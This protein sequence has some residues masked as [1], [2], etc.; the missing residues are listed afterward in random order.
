MNTRLFWFLCALVQ[1]SLA[2]GCHKTAPVQN[3]PIPDT[4]SARTFLALGDSYTIGES[5][6]EVERFPAQTISLLRAKGIAVKSPVY[7]ARTGWT[8]ANL[9][10]AIEQAT[11][12]PSYDIVTLLIGVNDQY[13]GKDTAGYRTRFTQL[14]QRSIELS[15]RNSKHVY[16]LSIP[17]YGVTPFGGGSQRISREIDDFNKINKEVSLAYGAVYIDITPI[18]R[19][20]ASDQSYTA[21]D[22]LHPSAKQY[23]EWAAQLAAVLP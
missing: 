3:I 22:G 17:D 19:K 5:V 16:V 20:A 9:Q 14:L 13:Q 7:I 21:G 11:L 2:L 15:G 4:T 8:T 12:L 10:S 6:A 18:S 1:C 23:G